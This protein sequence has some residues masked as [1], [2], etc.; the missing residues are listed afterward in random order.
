MKSFLKKKKKRNKKIVQVTQDIILGKG[1]AYLVSAK[2]LTWNLILS[3]NHRD[4]NYHS[5]I[6]TQL[7][8]F[9]NA[10]RMLLSSQSNVLKVSQKILFIVFLNV[11]V[12]SVLSAWNTVS[13]TPCLLSSL[14]FFYLASV[15][16]LT[17]L[18]WTLMLICPQNSLTYDYNFNL[19]HPCCIPYALFQ[20]KSRLHFYIHLNVLNVCNIGNILTIFILSLH[21]PTKPKHIKHRVVTQYIL[22]F[23]C[24]WKWQFLEYYLFSEAFFSISCHY[25]I[26]ILFF[27]PNKCYI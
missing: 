1:P 20:F 26:L 14:S 10:F 8:I 16:T 11:L 23:I 17:G 9:P 6:T 15:S 18:F 7:L 22:L 24:E 25:T 12:Y 13:Q 2:S 19:M 4:L 5:N 27:F 21:T 3:F